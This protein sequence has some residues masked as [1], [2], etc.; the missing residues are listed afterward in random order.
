MPSVSSKDD[1]GGKV[2]LKGS[3]EVGEALNIKHM[4]FIDE[5]DSWN[6]LSNT[7]VDVFVNY[8]ID[9]QS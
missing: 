1:D 5:E 8:L 2:A 9:F 4:N 3:V 6:Q 7:V